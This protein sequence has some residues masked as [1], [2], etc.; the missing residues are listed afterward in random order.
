MTWAGQG[1][2]SCQSLLARL[3]LG[4]FYCSQA[5]FGLAARLDQAA[6][7]A[8]AAA[9]EQAALGLHYGCQCLA[10]RPGTKLAKASQ[11]LQVS[12]LST[13]SCILVK[14][15]RC[16]EHQRP[17]QVRICWWTHLSCLSPGLDLL[18]NQ[19]SPRAAHAAPLNYL[20]GQ[21]AL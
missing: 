20:L 12:T 14:A 9:A 16:H 7:A 11:C 4:A 5:C 2:P 18:A 6:S 10:G 1:R 8:A 3:A 13:C 21:L 17:A 19:A 15:G